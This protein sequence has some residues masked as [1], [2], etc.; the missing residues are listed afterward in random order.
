MKECNIGGGVAT[1]KSS[2]DGG[3]PRLFFIN[4]R[5]EEEIRQVED[6]GE[7]VE[8]LQFLSRRFNFQLLESVVGGVLFPSVATSPYQ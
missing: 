6:G 5:R 7:D 1:F 2:Q 4:T 8:E 3:L